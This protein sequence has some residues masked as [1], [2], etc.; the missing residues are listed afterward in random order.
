MWTVLLPAVWLLILWITLLMSSMIIYSGST[1]IFEE[2]KRENKQW[3]IFNMVFKDPP[4][5]VLCDSISYN[6]D[7]PACCLSKVTSPFGLLRGLVCREHQWQK[8]NR[9]WCLYVPIWRW[10]KM[11]DN[12]AKTMKYHM[13]ISHMWSLNI[14]YQCSVF[15]I[16]YQWAV[17]HCA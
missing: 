4:A 9:C 7:A 16:N 8:F 3:I 17:L 2:K 15:I 6:E 10:S 13:I 11:W 12:K 5:P 1:W 14:K